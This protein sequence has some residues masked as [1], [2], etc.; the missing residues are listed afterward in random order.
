MAKGRILVI[1][2]EDIVRI[3]CNRAL[4]PEGYEVDVAAG[5]AEGLGLFAKGKYDLVLIDLKMPGIDGLEVLKQVRQS[6]PLQGILIMT[7]YNAP[8]NA[9]SLSFEGSEYLEKPFTPDAL[10]E[11]IDNI[12]LKK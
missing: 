10:I 6:H 1:D 9:T 2:D 11:K 4:T 12:L 8:D 5:G 3:S 7:G